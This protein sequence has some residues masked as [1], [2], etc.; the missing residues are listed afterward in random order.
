MLPD[1]TSRQEHTCSVQSVSPL[2]TSKDSFAP[3]LDDFVDV[4]RPTEPG[5]PWI[6]HLWNF[7]HMGFATLACTIRV[8]T[9]LSLNKDAPE[10]R[11]AQPV[12]S[13][14]ALPELGGLHNHHVRI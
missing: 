3:A 1:R 2:V 14:I 6:E 12:G 11:Q 5:M 9:H 10:F 13:I 7:S 4:D 8:R